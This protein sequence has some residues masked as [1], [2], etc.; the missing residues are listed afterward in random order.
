VGFAQPFALKSPVRRRTEPLFH[1]GF[2]RST[3][4]PGDDVEEGWQEELLTRR[5]IER[6][7]DRWRDTPT[8]FLEELPAA[9][10]RE[11]RVSPTTRAAEIVMRLAVSARIAM[12]VIANLSQQVLPMWHRFQV[13]VT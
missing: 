9:S 7:R 13:S 3:G 11:D 5:P 4:E 10:E 2:D 6:V 8:W 12:E 1:R